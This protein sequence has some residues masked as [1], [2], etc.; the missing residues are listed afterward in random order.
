MN[1]PKLGYWRLKNS[2]MLAVKLL[3]Q[4]GTPWWVLTRESINDIFIYRTNYLIE[5]F[6]NL[7]VAAKKCFETACGPE[8]IFETTS[9]FAI[10]IFERL[11]FFLDK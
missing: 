10:L 9:K 5:Y 4:N 2:K 11:I 8:F 1:N 6:R 7:I 3:Q